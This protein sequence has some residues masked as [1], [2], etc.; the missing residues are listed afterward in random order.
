MMVEQYQV[1]QTH[2]RTPLGPL[3]GFE[4]YQDMREYDFFRFLTILIFRCGVELITTKIK[5]MK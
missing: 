2:T 5:V 1:F 4:H 3:A